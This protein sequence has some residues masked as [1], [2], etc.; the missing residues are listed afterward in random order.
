MVGAFLE[1][2]L[3]A[4]ACMYIW[5]KFPFWTLM[6]LKSAGPGYELRV[7]DN[8]VIACYARL[9]TIGENLGLYRHFFAAPMRSRHERHGLKAFL[10]MM[11]EL[12]RYHWVTE[13]LIPAGS[14]SFFPGEKSL[15]GSL[16][17][18]HPIHIRSGTLKQVHRKQEL[19]NRQLHSETAFKAEFQK[20]ISE[21]VELGVSDVDVR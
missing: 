11:P 7:T 16:L 4:I 8:G 12:T 17:H 1:G 9:V 19:L 14:E 10:R 21:S 5:D 6:N 20:Q 18:D 13:A 3:S 2:R 15:A